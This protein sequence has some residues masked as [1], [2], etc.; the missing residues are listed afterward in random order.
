MSVFSAGGPVKVHKVSILFGHRLGTPG[1]KAVVDVEIYDGATFLP[2]GKV[3][4]GARLFK[5]SN[6]STNLQIQTNGINEFKLPSPVSVPSGRPVIGFRMIQTLAG[7]SCAQGYDANFSVDAAGT[8]RPGINILDAPGPGQFGLVDPAVFRVGGLIPLCPGIF[9]GS[10]VIRAC[11]KPEVSTNWTGNPSPGGVLSFTF[12]APG[13]AGN[14]YYAM[15]SG[16]IGTGFQTP[17]GFL[18]LDQ[19]PIF[20]CFL[21]PCSIFLIGRSGTIGANG[22]GFGGMSIPNHPSLKNSGLKLYVGFVTY[23]KPN[24]VPWVTVSA[25]S[26]VITIN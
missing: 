10:W 23:V 12:N 24:F 26:R 18:P 16:G 6:A 9:S 5:L 3:T 15:V 25:P 20:D 2:G 8:C 4:L 14:G 7:G 22:Q 17:W 19:D 21:G 1:V 13:Q 11:V